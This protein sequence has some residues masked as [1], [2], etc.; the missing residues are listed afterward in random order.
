MT[1]FSLAACLFFLPSLTLCRYLSSLYAGPAVCLS[2]PRL[3]PH[4][5][6]VPHLSKTKPDAQRKPYEALPHR[7]LAF[8]VSLS[9]THTQKHAHK[10][11][12]DSPLF[13][14]DCSAFSFCF[15]KVKR[16]QFPAAHPLSLSVMLLNQTKL[17]VAK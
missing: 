6:N 4:P 9:L 13:P 17:R 8:S 16:K 15:F 3:T 10:N 14:A 11:T 1:T 2:R 7:C 5:H 12:A